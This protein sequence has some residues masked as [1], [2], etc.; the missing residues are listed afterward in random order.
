[1]TETKKVHWDGQTNQEAVD[2]LLGEGGMIVSPTKVGYI[3]GTSDKE[4]LERKFAVKHRKRNKPGV[5]LCG[6][7]EQLKSL[8]KMTPEIE[9]FYQQCWDED[10]LM[11]CI[12][13]WQEEAKAKYMPQ[14]GAEELATDVRGTSCFVIRFG[15]PG[16][17]IAHELWEREGRL[18]FASSAN[19]SGKGNRGVVEGIGEEIEQEA[20]LIIE[21][22]DYVASIQP[23]KDENTRYEQGV[24]V[25]FVEDESGELV[26]EQHGERDVTPAPIL[27]RKGVYNDRILQILADHFNSWDYRHGH[28]Y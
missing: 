11:G 4:G 26:P 21:A 7:M 16:E 5:T 17:Q 20:D 13:P 15:V 2:I 19:P 10:I 1:M 9:A 24:M 22:D 3:I 23:N 8:A 28:Y 25:S 6:S 27:I 18:M 12:L 14:D